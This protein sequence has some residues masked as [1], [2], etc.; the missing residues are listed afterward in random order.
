[1]NAAWPR[2]PLPSLLQ[3][4]EP[5]ALATEVVR[6]EKKA[7]SHGRVLDEQHNGS[8]GSMLRVNELE[9]QNDHVHGWPIDAYIWRCVHNPE[10]K[11][12]IVDAQYMVHRG[13]PMLEGEAINGWSTVK[14][15]SQGIGE[16]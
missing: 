2:R 11:I 7:S 14:E 6:L 1:M 3:V 9:F 16:G 5:D 8:I 4:V 13:V 15:I 12:A 10:E